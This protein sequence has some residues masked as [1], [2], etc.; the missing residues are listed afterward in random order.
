MTSCWVTPEIINAT[1]PVA[2]CSRNS[3]V[4]S[5]DNSHQHVTFHKFSVIGKVQRT[6]DTEK[7]H[8]TADESR[9]QNLK[10]IDVS[11]DVGPTATVTLDNSFAG[12]KLHTFFEGKNQ[13]GHSPVLTVSHQNPHR[14]NNHFLILL[15]V[16]GFTV[17]STV[18]LSPSQT[19]Q[20]EVQS[21]NLGDPLQERSMAQP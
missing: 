14:F 16:S 8:R 4:S 13:P 1:S 21:Q 6:Q 18:R 5:G 11:A 7:R 19:A 12:A 3:C 9:E 2:Q 15:M 20:P 17:L 10:K